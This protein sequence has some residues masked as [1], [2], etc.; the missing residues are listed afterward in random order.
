MV[1][2]YYSV[3]NSDEKKLYTELLL[4]LKQEKECASIFKSMEKDQILKIFSSVLSDNPEIFYI[5]ISHTRYGNFPAK[6][7]P[8]YIY[9]GNEISGR[10]FNLKYEIDNIMKSAGDMSTKS[11]QMICLFIHNYLMRTVTYD[12]AAAE[13]DYENYRDSYSA[14]GALVNKKAVCHG[15]ALAF[16]LLCDKYGIPCFV[17]SGDTISSNGNKSPHSWNVVYIDGKYAHVDVTWDLSLTLSCD[18]KRYDYFLISEDEI[19]VDR[20]IS[21][22]IPKTDDTSDLGYFRST[23]RYFTNMKDLRKYLITEADKKPD[24]IC[25]KLEKSKYITDDTIDNILEKTDGIVAGILF[26][27]GQYYTLHNKKQLVFFYGI[28]YPHTSS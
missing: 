19:T 28:E 22:K 7:C 13:G 15:I 10:A 21:Q 25:F 1:N 2:Y 24:F 14:Y 11:K 16:K 12:S 8:D 23:G 6:I 17:V 3:L 18:Y 9:K 4:A 5:D 26:T 27:G 20:V